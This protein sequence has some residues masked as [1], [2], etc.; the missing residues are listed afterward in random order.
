MTDVKY[1]LEELEDIAVTEVRDLMVFNDDINTF[2]HVIKTLMK[3]CKHSPE[4][5]EQCAWI[6]HYKGKCCVK[7]GYWD[8]LRP[9][10]Q[11][12][13]EAGIDARVL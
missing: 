2:E 9:L 13:C 12:I 1:K 3:V 7:H 11:A 6:I 4:Q 8:E 5:A 10:Q